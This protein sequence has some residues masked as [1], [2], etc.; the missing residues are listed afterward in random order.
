M[1]G[2]APPFKPGGQPAAQ[3]RPAAAEGEQWAAAEEAGQ[4]GGEDEPALKKGKLLKAR[5]NLYLQPQ[6]LR[7]RDCLQ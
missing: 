2:A 1:E 6:G 3:Q 5:V 7:P 4:A